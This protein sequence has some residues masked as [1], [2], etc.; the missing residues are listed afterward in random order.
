MAG[1]WGW[2]R[3]LGGASGVGLGGYDPWVTWSVG[4]VESSVVLVEVF[5]FL[6]VLGW[7]VSSSGCSRVP[8]PGSS[9]GGDLAGGRSSS[10]SGTCF[11]PTT[12]SGSW[13]RCGGERWLGMGWGGRGWGRV[14][15]IG[16]GG[17]GRWDDNGVLCEG[18]RGK[19]GVGMVRLKVNL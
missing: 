15:G 19:A 9:R 17:V 2:V 18:T 10:R 7:L 16:P 5:P 8:V 3:V 13:E 11:Y 6:G 4:G 12:S 14:R 1:A